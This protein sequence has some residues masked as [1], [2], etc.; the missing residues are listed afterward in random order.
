MISIILFSFFFFNYFSEKFKWHKNINEIV[1]SRISLSLI[2][3]VNTVGLLSLILICLKLSNFPILILAILSNTLLCLKFKNFKIFETISKYLKDTESYLRKIYENKGKFVSFLILCFLLL[4]SIGPINHPDASK[5]YVGYIYKFWISNTHLIDGGLHQG[6]L[7]LI[8]FANISFFQEK[9]VW[10][11]RSLH[12]LPFLMIYVL[13]NLRKTSTIISII[14]FTSPVIIQWITIGKG[15]FLG[16]SCL[17]LTFLIWIKNK[18]TEAFIY[19][20]SLILLTISIKI[21]SLITIFPIFIYLIIYFFRNKFKESF[22]IIFKKGTI[23]IVYSLI[24][25]AI[26]IIYKY[27]VTGNIIYP[28]FNNLIIPDDLQLSEFWGYLSSYKKNFF[29]ISNIF[30]PIDPREYGISLGLVTGILLLFIP[31]QNIVQ[32]K[33]NAKKEYIIGAI[34]ILLLLFFSQGRGD[35]YTIPLILILSDLRFNIKTLNLKSK[36][37]FFINKYKNIF[38]KSILNIQIFSFLFIGIFSI[39]QSF[40]TFFS[41]EDGMKNFANQYNLVNIV[42][43]E[44]QYPAFSE[45]I[46]TNLFFLKKD[47]IHSDLYNKCLFNENQ[48]NK[49]IELKYKICSKKYNV[50]EVVTTN[51]LIGKSELFDC[52]KYNYISGARNPLKRKNKYFFICRLV[53]KEK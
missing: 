3:G 27:H 13:F 34:Q 11:I 24:I 7:S 17:A 52:S 28:L 33:F 51:N 12:A 47:Y 50:K 39:Y 5:Y 14:L 49:N 15:M 29:N 25:L 38:F 45:N 22:L 32:K 21:S 44:T 41:Y 10:L 26:T 18:N 6:L 30:I 23:T 42:N 4:L 2:L 8:D 35:Y 43:N 37:F 1:L 9:S 31:I 48:K 16:E 20:I 40:Y 19:L 53:D 46:Y 36:K